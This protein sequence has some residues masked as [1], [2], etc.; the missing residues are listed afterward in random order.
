MSLHIMFPQSTREVSSSPMSEPFIAPIQLSV[1][2]ACGFVHDEVGA[3]LGRGRWVTQRTY[4]KT[5]G[6]KPAELELTHTYCPKCFAKVQET[7][8]RFFQKTG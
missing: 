2:C 5:H 3:N 7:V 1:C 6:V 4:H 8:R